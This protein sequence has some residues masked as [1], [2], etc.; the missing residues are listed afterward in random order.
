[1]LELTA[2][3]IAEITGGRLVGGADGS[4]RVTGRAVVDSRTVQTGDLFVAFPGERVDGHRFAEKAMADG[5]ALTLVTRDV[6]VPAVQVKDAL[7]AVTELGRRMLQRARTENPDLAVIA[8]TGSSGKTSTKDLLYAMLSRVGETIAPAGSRNNELG[9]PLTILEATATT[10]FLVLEMGARGIGHIRHLTE[11]APPDISVVLNVGTAHV[12]EFGG[13]DA[14]RIAK[15]ELVEAL[16][17]D[18]TAVLNIDDPR[19]ASMADATGARV[20]RTGFAADADITAVD[21][22]L[23]EDAQPSFE[24]RV[25]GQSRRIRLSLT[26]EHHVINALSAAGAALAA[27]LTLDEV[28]DGLE[29]ARSRSEGRMQVSHVRDGITIINDA[30][31][32]NP[33]SMRTALKALA[34]LGRTRR[35]IAVLGEM[36]ELGEESVQMHDSVGRLAVRLNVHQ[37]IVVGSG[38]RAIHNG[39]HLEGSFGG[40][41]RYVDSIDE[42]RSVLET[43]LQSGDIVLLK[44][45]NGAGLAALGEELVKTMSTGEESA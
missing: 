2:A 29:T 24:L 31:N 16:G 39:A 34:H 41:S 10:R 20:L 11:I 14:I 4:E 12:G 37:L 23:D 38:A 17:A 15:Q 25:A 32:A 40:E 43:I 26:G 8:I 1:M 13:Q 44:S 5:A 36:L 42:A 30:Y 3:D 35:T 33:D 21:V 45:S 18:G 9:L 19:V 6:G 7:E 22:D 27:G 28:A